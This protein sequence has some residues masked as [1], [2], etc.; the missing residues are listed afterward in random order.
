[1]ITFLLDDFEFSGVIDADCPIGV[2]DLV[3]ET[4]RVMMVDNSAHDTPFSVSLNFGTPIRVGSGLVC[5][6]NWCVVGNWRKPVARHDESPWMKGNYLCGIYNKKRRMSMC[7][8]TVVLQ[9]EVY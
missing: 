8:V 6:P 9:F 4:V 2:L 3:E 1:M 5:G 7:S